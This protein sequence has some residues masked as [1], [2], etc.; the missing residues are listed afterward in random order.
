[1]FNNKMFNHKENQ[2]KGNLDAKNDNPNIKSN[3]AGYNVR[4]HKPNFV[5]QDKCQNKNWISSSFPSQVSQQSAYSSQKSGVFMSN[6]RAS[7]RPE[8][9]IAFIYDIPKKEDLFTNKIMTDFF[10]ENGFKGCQ[11]QIDKSQDIKESNENDKAPKPFWTA[12]VKF[13][14]SAYL[15]QA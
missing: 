13:M 1:M 5:C 2:F 7:Q 15:K 8:D 4:Y 9:T 3:T 12:R 6:S 14:N 10:I 11:V